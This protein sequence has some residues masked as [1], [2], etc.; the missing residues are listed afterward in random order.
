MALFEN[1]ETAKQVSFVVDNRIAP[2]ELDFIVYFLGEESVKVALT[3]KQP[4][5]Q[6]QSFKM[7]VI[8][9]QL[10]INGERLESGLHQWQENRIFIVSRKNTETHYFTLDKGTS[11]QIDSSQIAD[12]QI[13]LH[14]RFVIDGDE[15][16]LQAIDNFAYLNQRKVSS[17]QRNK[18]QEGDTLLTPYFLLEK[19]EKYWRFNTFTKD[20]HFNPKVVYLHLV[21]EHQFRQFPDYSR[22]PRLNLEVPKDSF[23]IHAI[24]KAPNHQKNTLLRAIVPP[25]AMIATTVLVT[26]LSGRNPIMMMTM[27]TMSVVTVAF[28][29]SQYITDKRDQRAEKIQRESDYQHYLVKTVGE[30]TQSYGKETEILQYQNPSPK[31]LIKQIK[32]FSNRIYERQTYNKDFME[33]SFGL[34]DTP[35]KLKVKTDVNPRDL[36]KEADNLRKLERRFTSQRKVPMAVPLLEQTIGLIGTREVVSPFMESVLLQIAFFHSYHDVN[37]VSLVSRKDYQENWKKWR[38][39]PHFKMRELNVRGLVYNNQSKDIVLNGLY[40]ILTKRKQALQEAGREKPQFLPHYVLSMLDASYLIGHNLNELLAEDMSE[41][42]VTVV[43]SKETAN[44]LPE[45]VTTLVELPNGHYGRIVTQDNVYVQKDFKLYPKDKDLETSIRN[46]SN[47]HYIE[48]EKNSVPES[49]G[50]LEQY[51]V[52]KVSELEIATRWA[53]AEP[54]KSI[55][56]LIGWRGKADYVYWDLHERAH[57]PHALV[58]GTTG[59]GK[60]EFLTTYL[61]GLAIA[62]SPEDIGMLIIDWKGGGIANTLDKL[63]HFMGAI[64][65]LDGAGTERALASIKA[66]MDKRQREFAKYGVNNINGYMSLYKQRHN[67]KP[68]TLYPEKPLPHLVL[69]SDEFAELKSNVPEFLDELTSVARIGRSLGV[70]LILATQKPTGVVNDQIEANSTSKIALKMANIQDSNE[71][72]KTP[73]A[74]H[75]TNPGRGYLKVGQNE[76]YELFQSGYAGLPYDP[77]NVEMETTDERIYRI[78]DLGQYELIYDPGEEIQQGRDTSELPTQLEAVIEEINTVFQ[79]SKLLQPER[80]WLPNLEEH[81]ESPNVTS[82][83]KRN[84]KIPLAMVDLPDQQLQKNFDYDLEKRSHT[85]IFSSPGYGKSTVLQTIALNIARQNTPE[86]VQ[87]HLLDFGNNGLLPLR[88]LPHVSDIAMLEDNEKLQKMLKRI[89]AE[90]SRRKTLFKQTGVASLSQYEAKTGETLPI[91]IHFLDNYDGLPIEDKRKDKID[92]L[93]LQ[94]LREGSSLG[95]YLLLSAS[96]PGSVRMNMMSNI[97]TKIALYLNDENELATLIGKNRVSQETIA[98]RGQIMLDIPR[99]LQIYQPAKG[100][101]S[102]DILRNLEELV[103]QMNVMWRGVRPESIPMVPETLTELSFASYVKETEPLVL[104]VGLN[105][106]SVEIETVKLFQGRHIGIFT[107]SQRQA[108]LIL[109]HLYRQIKNEKEIS[110]IIFIDAHGGMENY[111]QEVPLYIGRS[112]LMTGGGDLRAAVEAL[113]TASIR[114][115]LVIVNSLSDMVEK[116]IYNPDDVSRWMST[117]QEHTQWIF[118]D[119]VAKIGNTFGS[120]TATVKEFVPDLFFGGNLQ[121]QHFVEYLTMEERKEVFKFNVLH[122]VQEEQLIHVVI[123]EEDEG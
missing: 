51:E 21:D 108:R 73:D 39:L 58:G 5:V 35:T 116:L 122:R 62:F 3:K 113:Q 121:N 99:A 95:L 6:Y 83:T 67:P 38:L 105:K 16:V 44:Q 71:L 79:Q 96:R 120:L 20:Y 57:G 54:S 77:E 46:L 43:W 78:N 52:Q 123:P 112:D 84:L 64:T 86:M 103:D 65:N 87:M 11:C 68:D 56:S 17:K 41:L 75:I 34:G 69:V 53:E 2:E 94:L 19:C 81:I 28:S 88:N 9:D 106:Y 24:E 109:S 45:T 47:L 18:L 74:A 14:N 8:N 60:S 63:P 70:H 82:T 42:G 104:N 114:K 119:S 37:F 32:D 26:M 90:M 101:L 93:L 85:A 27:G 25:L 10:Y 40:Q 36:S 76:V 111:N 115:R 107:E 12:I 29:I 118:I 61:I 59:S 31:E 80:P 102:A 4:Y 91:I 33:I 72:L 117:A 13:G 23:T 89:N 55:R 30:L 50:L 100:E 49:L 48:V 66:E 92:A 98:G 7:S 110:D 97:S 22:K 15:V 1:T